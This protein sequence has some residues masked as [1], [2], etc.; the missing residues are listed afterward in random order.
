MSLTPDP[1]NAGDQP[2]QP[3]QETTPAIEGVIAPPTADET[4]DLITDLLGLSDTKAKDVTPSSDATPPTGEP[5][6]EEPT[7]DKKDIVKEEVP[8]ITE[9]GST[10]DSA[11]TELRN[12]LNEQAK[13]DLEKVDTPE[14]KEEKKEEPPTP[15]PE[16]KD[17][18]VP[19]NIQ[20]MLAIT[21][22]EYDKVMDGEKG[23]NEVFTKKVATYV[24]AVEKRL[25]E[26]NEARITSLIKT[27]PTTIGDNVRVLVDLRLAT[28]RFYDRNQDLEQFRPIVSMVGNEMM[29]K[30]PDKP[31]H[32]VF[33][34]IEE[35]VRKRL[36]LPKPAQ[37]GV[38]PVRPAFARPVGGRKPEP[39]ALTGQQKEIADTLF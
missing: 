13:K 27:I 9:G 31:L 4:R 6:K 37:Q 28:Q 34:L 2:A 39:E 24:G 15:E 3:A 22:D 5:V 23:F 26:K 16:K 1:T 19:D 17:E 38:Q 10:E 8:P 36:K 30:N 7:P 25:I 29:A 18:P 32:E 11:V 12:Q 14:V 20:N 35:E 21:P 33:G